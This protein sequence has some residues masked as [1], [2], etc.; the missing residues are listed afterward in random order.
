MSD[1]LLDRAR[2]WQRKLSL[3]P[4]VE[5]QELV[6]FL[7]EVV[8]ELEDRDE[9]GFVLT[10]EAQARLKT[11]SIKTLSA[12]GSALADQFKAY[13]GV[14]SNDARERRTHEIYQAAHRI[15]CSKIQ[16]APWGF[17]VSINECIEEA[18][19]AYDEVRKK[20]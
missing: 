14:P 4:N 1:S 20:A 18:R 12:E 5:V 7:G 10:P 19:D 15:Y 17:H 11:L 8:R 13:R 2:E 6:T 3:M 16:S 9:A